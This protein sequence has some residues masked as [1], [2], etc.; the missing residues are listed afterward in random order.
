MKRVHFFFFLISQRENWIGVHNQWSMDSEHTEATPEVGSGYCFHSFGLCS[1][2]NSHCLLGLAPSFPYKMVTGHSGFLLIDFSNQM[3]FLIC[4]SLPAAQT[5]YLKTISKRKMKKCLDKHYF[6]LQFLMFTKSVESISES[7][8]I[9]C[10][11]L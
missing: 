5:W 7:K 2:Y 10:N 9:F 6:I 4:N 3:W 11:D 8:I 1:L